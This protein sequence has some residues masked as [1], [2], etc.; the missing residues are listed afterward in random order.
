MRFG[1]FSYNQARPWVPERQAFEELLEQ[2]QLTE[3]LGFDEAWFA[4]HRADLIEA[5][6]EACLAV[7]F[8]FMDPFHLFYLKLEGLCLVPVACIA[9]GHMWRESCPLGGELAA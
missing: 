1:S 9:H 5:G 8:H 3:R 2:I 7:H 6:E 4:E